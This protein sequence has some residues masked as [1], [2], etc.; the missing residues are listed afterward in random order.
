[1]KR[2]RQEPLDGA[3]GQILVHARDRFGRPDEAHLYAQQF[4]AV[5]LAK[6][7]F[8]SLLPCPKI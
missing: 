5:H 3:L 8:R 6:M 4:I 2:Q 7:R 1:M